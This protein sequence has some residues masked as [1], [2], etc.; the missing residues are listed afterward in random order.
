MEDKKLKIAM[1]MDSYLPTVDGVVMCMHNYCINASKEHEVTALAPKNAKNYVDNF[2]YKVIRC[3]SF[4]IPIAKLY[5]GTPGND[6]KFKKAVYAQDYDIIH[7]H[8]PF[9][10]AK[11]AIKLAKAK[12]NETNVDEM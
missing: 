8:S 5:Y 2:P 12:N 7:L 3:S 6:A 9:N 11:F 1:A 4:Y 10:M